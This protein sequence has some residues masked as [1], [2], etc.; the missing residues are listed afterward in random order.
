MRTYHDE[1]KNAV[2]CHAVGEEVLCGVDLEF[3]DEDPTQL[4]SLLPTDGW[5]LGDSPDLLVQNLLLLFAEASDPLLKGALL[6]DSHGGSAKLV[7]GRLAL[8]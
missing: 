4:A 6:D 1:L 3:V 7:F 5:I 8:I 2:L